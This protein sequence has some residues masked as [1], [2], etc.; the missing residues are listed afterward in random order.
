MACVRLNFHHKRRAFAENEIPPVTPCQQGKSLPAALERIRRYTTISSDRTNPLSFIWLS[1]FARVEGKD[2]AGE[3]IPP[4]LGRR[5]G[6]TGRGAQS[7]GRRSRRTF[8]L[9]I[10]PY[11][12]DF[13]DVTTFF[14]ESSSARR[15]LPMRARPACFASLWRTG[16]ARSVG[17][18]Q[19]S[20]PAGWLTFPVTITATGGR[21]SRRCSSARA[22]S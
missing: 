11:L 4:C 10:A 15:F 21:A 18:T 12:L 5:T 3:T 16:P 9:R 13:T 22:S 7:A 1:G 2:G 20:L 6:G 14:C 19:G 8:C 17:F